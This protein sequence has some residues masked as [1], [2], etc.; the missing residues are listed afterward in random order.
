MAV[1]IGKPTHAI[2][3]IGGGDEKKISE[4]VRDNLTE[5]QEGLEAL[6]K[7]K[8]WR[9]RRVAVLTLI[10]DFRDDCAELIWYA[11]GRCVLE[12]TVGEVNTGDVRTVAAFL[13]TA[14]NTVS[15]VPHVAIG[16]TGHGTGIFGEKEADDRASGGRHPK[17]RARRMAPGGSG[18]RASPL[19]S[20]EKSGPTR[21]GHAGFRRR[22][23]I[24]GIRRASTSR[25]STP[26]VK[27]RAVHLDH[28]PFT[29][30]K[31]YKDLKKI[32]PQGTTLPSDLESMGA[33]GSV[34]R[35]TTREI[36]RTLKLA[37]K[38]SGRDSRCVDLLFFDGCSNAMV[39]VTHECGRYA[40]MVVASM[41]PEDLKLWDYREWLTRMGQVPQSELDSFQWGRQAVEAFR[42]AYERDRHP[43]MLSA[44]RTGRAHRAGVLRAFKRLVGAL[45]ESGRDGFA[46][47][48][49]ALDDTQGFAEGD[50]TDIVEF[51]QR[52]RAEFG[53]DGG[54]SAA[55][56]KLMCAVGA[57]VLYHTCVGG[58]PEDLVPYLNAAHGLAF[59]FPLLASGFR[60]EGQTYKHLSFAKKSGWYDYLEE[61]Y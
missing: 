45:D 10:D 50:S 49:R 13:A 26:A 32:S 40:D 21:R 39:E 11:K 27:K 51:A 55:C 59:W 9:R 52:L 31:F 43:R 41:N 3:L 20:S 61:N 60:R 6:A 28:H 14:L 44:I 48:R 30:K 42:V 15:E 38:W 4:H 25:H 18:P 36:A 56:D 22:H 17:R 29:D 24:D 37:F 5:I 33:I 23:R 2:I 35:L 7:T 53:G 47:A 57:A 58:R 46:K 19:G 8:G 12:E 16:F 54:V 34:G 1:D